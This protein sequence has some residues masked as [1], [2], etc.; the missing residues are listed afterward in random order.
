MPQ[1]ES[2]TI[3]ERSEPD[4][5][6]DQG[7]GIRLGPEVVETL[8]KY[9][10]FPLEKYAVSFTTYRM[11]GDDG[12][13]LV[14]SSTDNWSTS[15]G[16]LFYGLRQ[17]FEEPSRE[18]LKTLYRTGCTATNVRDEGSTLEVDF[19]S[20]G[21]KEGCLADLVVGADGTS[22]TVRNLV[23]RG[24]KRSYA[25]YVAL[26]GMVP[27]PELSERTQTTFHR[28][29]GFCFP[30]DSAQVVMYTVPSSEQEIESGTCLNW[31][32]YRLKTVSE[33]EDLMTDGQGIR[34][35]YTLPMGKMREEVARAMKKEA[36][37]GMAPQAIEVIQ[38]TTHPFAQTVT[39]NIAGSNSFLGGKL[40]LVGDAAAGQRYASSCFV[41]RGLL[42]KD[43][44]TGSR[45]HSASAL[46]QASFHGLLLKAL[47]LRDI[48]LEQWSKETHDFS[49]ILINSG[50][51]LGKTLVLDRIPM[52]ARMQ[53]YWKQF[54]A[55]QANLN[56]KWTE[57]I[58][59]NSKL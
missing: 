44:L 48:S 22:S 9:A 18:G 27:T 24:S 28:A 17:A 40:L 37:S 26:R 25:G 10:S 34:H 55:T 57:A 47:L 46:T 33:L 36:E 35:T 6:K 3:L 54:S 51:E 5:L 19:E 4:K 7:A 2:I 45:P 16:R 49:S 8:R 42:P 21:N 20:G 11:L 43:R 32:W 41:I 52:P 53:K 13:D 59:H 56:A 23:E 39:D 58:G 50:H 31:V 1:I 29:G 15:W 30:Q 12:E 14:K 38:K